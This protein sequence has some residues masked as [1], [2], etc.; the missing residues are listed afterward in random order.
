MAVAEI[1]PRQTCRVLQR[2]MFPYDGST[3]GDGWVGWGAGGGGGGGEGGMLFSL[4][5]FFW[6]VEIRAGCGWT[7]VAVC[8]HQV[9]CC[10]TITVLT[11]VIRAG[12]ALCV[13]VCGGGGGV[14]FQVLLR[15]AQQRPD[16]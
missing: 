2:L 13:C 8:G 9:F 5:L 6:P 3:R 7:R 15:S 12:V 4:A 1:S 11:A 14:S 16:Y 10:Q